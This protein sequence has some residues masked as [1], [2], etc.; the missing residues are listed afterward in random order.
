M[1][2]RALFFEATRAEERVEAARPASSGRA[3]IAFG[4]RFLNAESFGT[5]LA[6][7]PLIGFPSQRQEIDCRLGA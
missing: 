3:R 1:N 5:I 7:Q 2:A 4:F 6:V